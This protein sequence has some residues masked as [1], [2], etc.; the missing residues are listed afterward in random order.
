[1][2]K[3]NF[4]NNSLYKKIKDFNIRESIIYKKISGFKIQNS[5][6][7]KKFQDLNILE[8]KLYNQVLAL[9][10]NSVLCVILGSLL[11]SFF[12]MGCGYIQAAVDTSYT[13]DE[14]EVE[15]LFESEQQIFTVSSFDGLVTEDLSNNQVNFDIDMENAVY[16]VEQMTMDSINNM[17]YTVLKEEY[18]ANNRLASRSF[19]SGPRTD[20]GSALETKSEKYF[21][22]FGEKWDNRFGRYEYYPGGPEEAEK[23]MVGFYITV[24][25]LDSNNNWYQRRVYLQTHKNIET[26]VKC[27]FSELLDLPEKERT[28]IK[29]IGCFNYRKGDSGH[30]CGVAIDINYLENAE[31][32]KEG[33][34]TCGLYWRPYE[35][36]YSIPPDGKMVEI[37]AKYGFGWGGNWTSKKDYMHF[38]YFDL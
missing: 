29:S 33:R 16:K 3:L 26:T 38:C 8:N 15:L 17:G 14:V 18:M 4:K 30:T 35:D 36:I 25:S 11:F 24:W 9:K 19:E 37:F 23:D 7:Y 13:L 20:V 2:I 1:M 31:M 5:L 12:G 10:N 21:R 27:I 6:L 28:P 34:V 22:I 32:T